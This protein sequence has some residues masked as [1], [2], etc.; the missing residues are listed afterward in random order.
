VAQEEF[1]G[2]ANSYCIEQSSCILVHNWETWTPN[3]S[4]IEPV[5]SEFCFSGVRGVYALVTKAIPSL[6]LL[7]EDT[8]LAK[9]ANAARNSMEDLGRLAAAPFLKDGSPVLAK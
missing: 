5:Y 1:G 6:A 2:S 4:G 8:T 9:C 7:V 3:H